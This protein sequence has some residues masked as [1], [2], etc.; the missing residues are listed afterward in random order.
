MYFRFRNSERG[1]QWTVGEPWKRAYHNI[2][3]RY[4]IILALTAK[5]SATGSPA[6]EAPPWIPPA[7]DGSVCPQ[8][9]FLATIP[10]VA[11]SL[12]DHSR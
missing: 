10:T 7:K 3:T 2:T 8:F 5:T 1:T 11:I 4:C 12:V 9:P 6:P